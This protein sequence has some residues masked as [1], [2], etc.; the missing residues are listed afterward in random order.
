VPVAREYEPNDRPVLG[1]AFSDLR[2]QAITRKENSLDNRAA[3]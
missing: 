2:Y 3:F 1:I